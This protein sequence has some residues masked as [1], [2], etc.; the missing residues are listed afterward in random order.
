MR[1]ISHMDFV[2][3]FTA[4]QAQLGVECSCLFMLEVMN[5]PE[6]LLKSSNGIQNAIWGGG[7]KG[8]MR[9]GCY[10]SDGKKRHL[11][12]TRLPGTSLLVRK[13]KNAAFGKWGDFN[14]LHST[15]RCVIGTAKWRAAA[16]F[17]I[18]FK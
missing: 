6:E 17:R 16:S 12:R 10:E 8:C 14:D 3:I 5:I 7:K 15:A 2:C 18:I 9:R 4:R 11:L 13:K 1:E